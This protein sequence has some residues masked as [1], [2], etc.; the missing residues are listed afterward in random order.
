MYAV[1]AAMK[2]QRER[3]KSIE[4]KPEVIDDFDAVMEVSYLLVFIKC[5]AVRVTHVSAQ[6]YFKKVSWHTCHH[7]SRVL[8]DLKVHRPCSPN[9]SLPGTSSAKQTEGLSRCGRVRL[10][11]TIRKRFGS[12]PTSEHSTHIIL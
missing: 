3:L 10:S 12:Q 11:L 6:E 8:P 1:M 9:P 7:N 2:L 5:R 4:V